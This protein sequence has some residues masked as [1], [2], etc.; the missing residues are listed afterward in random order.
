M[1]MD[2]CIERI[3]TVKPKKAGVLE[4]VIYSI[5]NQRRAVII[6][7]PLRAKNL[8][9]RCEPDA[10]DGNYD[11]HEKSCDFSCSHKKSPMESDCVGCSAICP[12]EDPRARTGREMLYQ[13]IAEVNQGKLIDITEEYIVEQEST[14]NPKIDPEIPKIDPEILEILEGRIRGKLPGL[15]YC[16]KK[17]EDFVTE[18]WRSLFSFE[19]FSKNKLF[20]SFYKF[21]LNLHQTRVSH[22]YHSWAIEWIKKKTADLLVITDMEGRIWKEETARFCKILYHEDSEEEQKV[23]NQI[24]RDK[25]AGIHEEKQNIRRAKYNENIRRAKYNENH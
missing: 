14:I 22:E 9:R 15:L 16:C 11:G 7:P 1:G 3:E 20:A 5:I 12:Y 23:L 10:E 2:T 13:V 17:H 4:V 24:K 6:S 25:E 21:G 8:K 19:E 18:K